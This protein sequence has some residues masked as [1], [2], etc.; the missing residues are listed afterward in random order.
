MECNLKGEL[1]RRRRKLPE[2]IYTDIELQVRLINA[3]A[4]AQQT[5]LCH[6]DI[7]LEIFTF[8]LLVLS[9]LRISAHRWHQS[10]YIVLLPSLV[11]LYSLL[12]VKSLTTLIKAISIH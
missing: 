2:V 1:G 12:K 11:L 9:N 7:H 4:Y 6:G 3:L 5:G 8:P 10:P